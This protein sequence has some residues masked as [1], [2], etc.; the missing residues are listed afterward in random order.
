MRSR[1]A[2][3]RPLQELLARLSGDEDWVLEAIGPPS[4]P[5]APVVSAG[6]QGDIAWWTRGALDSPDVV[7]TE[8]HVLL[9]LVWAQE[10]LGWTGS[11]TKLERR[12]DG[13]MVRFPKAHVAARHPRVLPL[14]A[15]RSE[16]PDREWSSEEAHDGTF[17]YRTGQAVW[18]LRTQPQLELDVT[19]WWGPEARLRFTTAPLTFPP[20]VLD[21][22]LD[23]D[24][25]HP[26]WRTASP[27][28]PGA[29]I[30][31]EDERTDGT[32]SWVLR[33]AHLPDELGLPHAVAA[34]QAVQRELAKR[35][36]DL[37]TLLDFDS[38]A[39][40]FFCY[41]ATEAP[42]QQLSAILDDL[43]VRSGR[44]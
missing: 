5:G 43:I 14:A 30:M 31:H 41:A 15:L 13:R 6:R 22:A 12:L 26:A 42:L 39:D 32:V 25:V 8:E 21:D 24:D 4:F 28:V 17:R 38:E 10:P 19:D 36:P 11:F 34:Q 7:T 3:P 18:V 2:F 1:D 20:S 44:H 23:A 35:R 40:E 37:L 29:R 33:D 9:E 16:L 27:T